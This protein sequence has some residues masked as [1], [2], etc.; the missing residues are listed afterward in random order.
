MVDG[1]REGGIELYTSLDESL[2]FFLHFYRIDSAK[3]MSFLIIAARQSEQDVNTF[4]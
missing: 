2:F 4:I 1:R 3:S